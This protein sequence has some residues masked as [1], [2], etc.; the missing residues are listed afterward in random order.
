MDI[1]DKI[2]PVMLIGVVLLIILAQMYLSFVTI[3][4]ALQTSDA[5]HG[6]SATIWYCVLTLGITHLI[7]LLVPSLEDRRNPSFLLIVMGVN[8]WAC[9]VYFK[10]SHEL[11]TFC[12][13]NYSS[14]WKI[15]RINVMYYV[16][17]NAVAICAIVLILATPIVKS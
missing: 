3:Y 12:K 1:A 16:I 8:I 5:M 2:I 11:A 7:N 6:Q 9:I 10:A 15:L 14:L 4:I 17:I 13:T